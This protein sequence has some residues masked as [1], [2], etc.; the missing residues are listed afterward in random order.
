MTLLLT[1]VELHENLM[2]YSF[3][4]H[5]LHTQI[6]C[7]CLLK[8]FWYINHLSLA[9]LNSEPSLHQCSRVDLPD[10]KAL[11]LIFYNR[12]CVNLNVSFFMLCSLRIRLLVRRIGIRGCV[13][14]GPLQMIHHQ[15]WG[16]SVR[17][18][19]SQRLIQTTPDC[20]GSLR[21]KTQVT[22]TL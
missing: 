11:H 15:C 10:L 7:F 12:T 2:F 6:W 17:S 16:P 5:L 14:P 19:Q 3:V 22:W 18:P 1:I 8:F 20:P 21:Q 13:C 9:G 4:Y